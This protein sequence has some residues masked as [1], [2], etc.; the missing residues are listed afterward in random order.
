MITTYVSEN[1]VFKFTL[2]VEPRSVTNV[3]GQTFIM[4]DFT[5]LG[6]EVLK[7]PYEGLME[8]GLPFGVNFDPYESEIQT[9]LDN[10]VLA[11]QNSSMKKKLPTAHAKALDRMKRETNRALAHVELLDKLYRELVES[12]KKETK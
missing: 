2:D 6:Y 1:G 11:E 3:R 8:E 4:H 9:A 12:K 7:G 10:S 5:V